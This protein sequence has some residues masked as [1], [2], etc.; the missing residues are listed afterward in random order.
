M[1]SETTNY[2][3]GLP[4]I[5]LITLMKKGKERDLQLSKVNDFQTVHYTILVPYLSTIFCRC[6]RSTLGLN[7]TGSTLSKDPRFLQTWRF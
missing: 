7:E 5:F 6:V 1:Y 3:L 4:E 2:T